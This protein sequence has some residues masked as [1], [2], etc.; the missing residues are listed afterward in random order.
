MQV[1]LIQEGP[2]FKRANSNGRNFSSEKAEVEGGV[3][4]IWSL[5]LMIYFLCT[6]PPTLLST[7]LAI[8][9][10]WAVEM[11]DNVVEVVVAKGAASLRG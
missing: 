6:T 7:A 11:R 1:F 9:I 10:R 4:D 8:S 2:S 5:C 3:M